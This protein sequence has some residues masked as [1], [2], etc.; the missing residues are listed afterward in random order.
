MK[1]ILMGLPI[2]LLMAGVVYLLSLIPITAFV[3]IMVLAMSW[4][5]GYMFEDEVKRYVEAVK[6]NR[7]KGIW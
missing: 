1:Y 6:R 2:V 7:E 4:I 3:V 5:A